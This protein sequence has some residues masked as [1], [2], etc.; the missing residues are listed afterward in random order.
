MKIFEQVV[1]DKVRLTIRKTGHESQWITLCET[2]I[3]EV[4][5]FLKKLINDQ[6]FDA[7]LSGPRTGI[8]IRE[9]K[10]SKNGKSISI[11][12]RGLDPEQTKQ[13]IINYIL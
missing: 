12:F 11:S 9:E 10:N 7:F 5:K 4:E 2:D 13:L 8:D 1:I 6:H 3:Y